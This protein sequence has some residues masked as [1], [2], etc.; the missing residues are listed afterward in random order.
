MSR[1]ASVPTDSDVTSLSSD[2]GLMACN[3]SVAVTR[4]ADSWLL[5]VA[6]SFSILESASAFLMVT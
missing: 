5:M 6:P 2:T 3:G 4:L 1:R